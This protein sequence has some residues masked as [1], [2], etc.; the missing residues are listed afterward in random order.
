[1][2]VPRTT[3]T[4]SLLANG[5]VLVTGGDGVGAPSEHYDPTTG[6]W[7]VSGAPIVPRTGHTATTL[8]SGQVLVTGGR[9][10]EPNPFVCDSELYD[11][12][13]G[14]WGRTGALNCGRNRHTATLLANGDVLV[15]GGS[16]GGTAFTRKG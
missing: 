5:K 13:T 2:H 11:P 15:V 1:M 4:A 14:L 8:P 10:E 7:T 12:A 6:L 16:T 3:P 9:D